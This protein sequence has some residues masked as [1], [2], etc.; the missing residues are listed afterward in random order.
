M[1]ERGS[2]FGRART[3]TNCC[4]S[5]SRFALAHCDAFGELFPP[6]VPMTQK[7]VCIAAPQP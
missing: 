6:F 2:G 1:I 7:S 3:Q 4:V 5:I